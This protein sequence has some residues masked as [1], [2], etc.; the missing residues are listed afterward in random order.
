MYYNHLNRLIGGYLVMA[1]KIKKIGNPLTVIGVFAGLAEIAMITA[2]GL[3]DKDLQPTFIWFVMGFPFLLVI[4]FFLTLNFNAKI[5][6]APSDFKD[7]KNFIQAI[8][9]IKIEQ[10]NKDANNQTK[11]ETIKNKTFKN[12]LIEI[13]GK[14]YSQC[15]FI[16][17][18]MKYSAEGYVGI[19]GCDLINSMWLFE[20]NA[21]Q[22]I[23]FL[24]ALYSEFGEDGKNVVEGTLDNIK[25]GGYKK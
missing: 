10:K 11:V 8:Q 16:N 24:T 5:L 18:T 9:S 1:Q 3:V 12:E 17:C 6:Y 2:L 13:D 7:E 20:S 21:A 19:I 4:L 14:D 25:N 15:K 23:M 22:T